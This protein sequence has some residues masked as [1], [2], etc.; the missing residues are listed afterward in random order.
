MT[1]RPNVSLDQAENVPASERD[2]PD[3]SRETLVAQIRALTAV[4][5]RQRLYIGS[6]RASRFWQL[7][8][9]FFALRRR[10]TGRPDPLPLTTSAD[11]AVAAAAFG[12]AYQLLRIRERRSDAEL[13]SLCNVMRSLDYRYCI[14]VIVNG[15]RFSAAELDATLASLGAQLYPDVIVRVLKE[16]WELL[17]LDSDSA[18]CVIE[19]GDLLETDALLSLAFALHDG[20]DVVYCDE[21]RLDENG[22]PRSPS[23][24]PDWSPE[25]ELTQLYVRG[26][27]VFRGSTLAAVGGFDVR[28]GSAMI[29][30]AVLRVTEVS[31]RVAHVARVLY[32]RRS[33]AK[34]SEAGDIEGAVGRALARRREIAEL[35]PTVSGIDVRF[36][37]PE[38]DRVTVIIP[39]RDRADL[40]ER[41][42]RALFERTTHCEFDVIIVDNGS[43]QEATRTLLDRWRS[44]HPQRF[45]ILDDPAAFNYSRLNN[46]AVA[47]T[48]APYVVLLNN[49]T[50]V[51]APDWMTAMLGQARRSPIGAVG[52]LLLYED[53]TVQ[54]AGV[55]LGGV[56]SLAGHAYRFADPKQHAANG[57]LLF[58]TNYLAVT[59]ACLMVAREKYLEVGGLDESLAVSY[60]DIDFC[61]KLHQAGYRNVVV[62]RATLYH[63]ESKTRGRDDTQ[64]KLALAIRES[65]EIRRRWPQWVRR[66]PYYNPNLTLDSEDFSVRS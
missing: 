22:V 59:G 54:H 28:H 6:M 53:G 2:T 26:L 56:L 63:Y 11:L 61:L 1:R 48:V 35:Y 21:D 9:A 27:C 24:K 33:T 34:A 19:A 37:V 45:R 13:E 65:D 8:N 39:T 50:E 46:E 4:V 5:R 7:R 3:P 12:D 29:D 47:Q 64:R 55:V 18:V 40:L 30:D 15:S 62:P 57:R 44:Q 31:D 32:H 25:T 49:D 16:A 51:I 60:N 41:C 58:D 36:A 10:L 17:S 66:D 23:F 42:L 14:T 38:D 20:A 43:R 52:A